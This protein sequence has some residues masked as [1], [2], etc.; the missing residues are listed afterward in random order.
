MTRVLFIKTLIN[1]TQFK[2]V[3]GKYLI[4][5][6]NLNG[7]HSMKSPYNE[8]FKHN[9]LEIIY[10]DFW[11]LT[12]TH[13]K[14]QEKIKLDS[15]K[16][17]H[18]NRTV[19]SNCNRGSGGVAIA[20]HNSVLVNHEVIGVYKGIDGQIGLKLLDSKTNLL[21]GVLGLYLSPD[22]Y[23]YGQDPETFFNEAFA[24]WEDLSDCDLL[25]GGG[26]M[27]ARI[28]ND[29]DYLPDVDEQVPPRYNPDESKNTHGGTF[30]TFL[31]D[32][33]AVVL[34]G[35][36]T[37]EL[38]N[39]TFVSTRGRSVPDHIFCPITHLPYCTRMET[40]LIKDIINA[41]KLPP[42]PSLPDHS[43]LRGMLYVS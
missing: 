9:I 25:V 1:P 41:F 32:N 22:S 26:D 38:N 24:I 19:N 18:H 37:P 29:D 43:I 3:Y 14:Y 21:I 6:W 12:E 5:E 36:V 28:R 34:N 31:K 30:L 11:I 7:Y 42:P 8:V 27:N 17:Y 33:R 10:S 15:Y 39:F 35:R 16:L 40:L 4:N 2:H 23:T 13:C 20:V